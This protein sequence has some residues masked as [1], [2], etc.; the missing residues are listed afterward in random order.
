VSNTGNFNPSDGSVV[1][2]GVEISLDSDIGVGFVDDCCRFIE[3]VIGEAQIKDKYKLS[4][5]DWERLA[6]NEPLQQAVARRQERRIFTGDAT[7]EKAQYLFLAAPDVLSNLLNNT[8]TPARSRIDAAKELRQVALGGPEAT[9]ATSEKF[10]I[11]ID[12]TASGGEVLEF[13]KTLAIEPEP[14]DK[15]L[16]IEPGYNKEAKDDESI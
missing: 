12:L 16:A 14:D 2:R 1:L 5:A 3:N 6:E 11:R 10:I 8:M 13:N 7:R 15:P 9:P 4:D